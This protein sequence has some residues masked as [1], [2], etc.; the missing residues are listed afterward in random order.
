[1]TCD[2]T[3]AGPFAFSETEVK[4]LAVYL[5]G[6]VE[7]QPVFAFMDF[8]AYSQYWMTP[9]GYD[10]VLPDNYEDQVRAVVFG[11]HSSNKWH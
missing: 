10:T 9:Y 1:M 2:D 11:N 7:R 3:Y 4:Q 6:L 8:H 5:T